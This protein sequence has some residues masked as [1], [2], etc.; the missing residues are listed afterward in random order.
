MRIV[1][2][3]ATM[4][5]AIK[6]ASI[7]IF[8]SI[9]VDIEKVLE[10]HVDKKETTWIRLGEAAKIA[11]VSP[12]TVRRWCTRRWIRWR[13][14]NRAK[15]GRVLIDLASLENFLAGEEGEGGVA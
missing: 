3:W 5:P 15:C 11:C 13:K 2:K 6:Q 4:P 14:L 9:G 12:Y 7:E 8:K 10:D 1:Q